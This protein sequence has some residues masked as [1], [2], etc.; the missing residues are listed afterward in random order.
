VCELQ[1]GLM[2]YYSLFGLL[3]CRRP[4]FHQS[5][6][7]THNP[8]HGKGKQQVRGQRSM[9]KKDFQRSGNAC[10]I[11]I[12]PVTWMA[13]RILT[14]EGKVSYFC[15]I[16][17]KCGMVVRVSYSHKKAGICTSTPKYLIYRTLCLLYYTT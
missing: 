2:I 8:S 13:D 12:E 6:V 11:F 10:D 5:G 15:C 9:D 4:L 1:L 17:C 7:V 3:F 16:F 14:I